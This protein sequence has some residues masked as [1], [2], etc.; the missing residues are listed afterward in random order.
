MSPRRRCRANRTAV[1]WRRGLTV[2]ELGLG[3][4]GA[5]VDVPERRRLGLV[6]LAAGEVAEERAL[7]HAPARRRRSSC[8]SSTSRPRARV[9]ATAPRTPARRSRDE[10]LAQLDEVA[11]ARSAIACFAGLLGRLEVGS[12]G[13]R[14]VAPDAEEVLH[15]TLGREAVVVPAHRVEDLAPAHA[16]VAGDGVGLGVPEHVSP[17]AASRSPSAAA[18][19]SRRRRRRRLG[20]VEAV[21]AVRLP[22]APHLSSRPSSAGF[23]G[24]STGGVYEPGPARLIFVNRPAANLLPPDEGSL[25]GAAVGP[26]GDERR[27][28]PLQH[29]AAVD[30]AA[31]DVGAAREVVHDVEEHL[32]ED[33]AA[34][35]GHRCR[36]S[37]PRRRRPRARRR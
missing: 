15:P 9:A 11:A 13:Q 12:Y 22:G 14:R 20:A 28:H 18:C 1:V 27:R 34:A 16:L 30:D 3:D 19:R 5:E 24:T 21:G 35:L 32:F 33:G 8:T 29:D 37:A 31:R 25:R 17:C 10:A 7:R 26:A 36:A 6:R 2:L 23:S 4:R